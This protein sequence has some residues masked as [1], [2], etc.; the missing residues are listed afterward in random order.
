MYTESQKEET[1]VKPR[2]LDIS[3]VLFHNKSKNVLD[4]DRPK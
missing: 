3:N 2:T 1:K 4:L